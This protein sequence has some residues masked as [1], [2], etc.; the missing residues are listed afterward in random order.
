MESKRVL[1]WLFALL[2]VLAAAAVLWLAWTILQAL[3]P[4]VTVAALGALLA[5]L[6]GPLADRLH[7]AI[8]SR[9]VAALAVV[10]L[11]LVPFVL[12]VAWLVGTVVVEAQALLTRLP[13]QLHHLNALLQ[14]WQAILARFGVNVDLAGQLSRASGGVLRRSINVL[15]GVATV[16]TD[17]VLVL[18]VA[19]FLIWDGA[20]MLRSFY[21]LVPAPWQ[22]ATRDVGRILSQVVAGYVRGQ[23]LVGALFGAIVGTGM[24]ALGLPDAALLGFLAGIFELVPAVGPILGAIGPIGLALEQPF[25]HVLWVLLVL[26]AAQQLESNLL[27]PRISGGAVGLHPVTVILAVFGGWNLAGFTGA[28]L[29]VPAVGV[30]REFLRQWWQPA[31]PAPGRRAWPSPTPAAAHPAPATER[32]RPAGMSV[33]R[34]EPPAPPQPTPTPG[35]Q[36]VR[37]RQP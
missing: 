2:T 22:P 30:V 16:T 28:L 18:I 21:R 29:A 36:R 10:L 5:V 11:V 23:V 20:A 9:P 12:M 32:E 31:I 24:A 17:T 14:S 7:R 8:R 15:T 33:V 35:P 27:V 34:A 37:R 1:T 3:A 25:P 4:M 6:L 26:V 13:Q 19:F